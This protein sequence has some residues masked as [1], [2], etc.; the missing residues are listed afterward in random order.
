MIRAPFASA[1]AI[2]AA[3]A[4]PA[5]ANSTASGS[6]SQ[7][8]PAASPYYQSSDSSL[9]PCSSFNNPNAG[10][11]ADKSTGKAKEHSASAV[12]KDCD[13]GT[14]ASTSSTSGTSDTTASG[15]TMTA[16]NSLSTSST[17]KTGTSQK[18]SK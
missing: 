5:F 17:G 9:T 4:V 15:S 1:L 2:A 12:H 3:A 6:T 13:P 18:P 8:S 16:S 14:S 11:L 10:K 7:H